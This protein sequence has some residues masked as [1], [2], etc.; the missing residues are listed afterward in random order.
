MQRRILE[1]KKAARHQARRE[2]RQCGGHYLAHEGGQ[3]LESGVALVVHICCL[4]P[5]I[6]QVGLGDGKSHFACIG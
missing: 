4:P 3:I 2:Y 6:L 1:R 5:E